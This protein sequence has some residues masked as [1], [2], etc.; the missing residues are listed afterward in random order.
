MKFEFEIVYPHV[1][2]RTGSLENVIVGYARHI[3]VHCRTGSLETLTAR[4]GNMIIVHC[5]TGSL[6]IYAQ[7]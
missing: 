7:A 5:R 1:H 3:C 6:E 2:C 4:S